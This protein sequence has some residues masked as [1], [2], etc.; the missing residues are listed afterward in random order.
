M[1]EVEKSNSNL[2]KE[3]E[4]LLL[5][6]SGITEDEKKEV[7]DQIDRVVEKNKISVTDELFVT[8]PVKKGALFPIL[9][10]VFALVL[11]AGGVFYAYRVF[12]TRQANLSTETQ[13]YLS[14]EGKLIEEIKKESEAQL[15]RKEE[16][17]SQIQTELME[18]DRQSKELKEN[19]EAEIAAREEQLKKE[20]ETALEA[21]R[22]KLEEEGISEKEINQRLSAIESEKR[23]QYENQ[24][25]SFRQ[26]TEAA[27]QE[28]ENELQQA[29]EL[30]EEVLERANRERLQLE[31]ETDRKISEL[32]EDFE[33]QR[34]ALQSEKSEAQER[35]RELS[36]LREQEQLVSDQIVGAYETIIEKIENSQYD[37]AEVNIEQLKTLLADSSLSSLP[38]IA[39]RREIDQYLLS[40]LKEHLETK[41]TETP[42]ETTSIV[43]AAN[44]L[45]GARELVERGNEALSEG[46]Q[47]MAKRL[48][49]TALTEVPALYKAY[50]ELQIIERNEYTELVDEKIA[51]G[52][53]L[54]EEGNIDAAISQ[55]REGITAAT[56]AEANVTTRAAGNI[57]QVLT[58]RE[59]RSVEEKEREIAR[60][61][62]RIERLVVSVEELET[63]VAA[64]NE[65]IASLQEQ[66]DSR[67]KRITSL[68]GIIE[69]RNSDMKRLSTSIDERNSSIEQLRSEITRQKNEIE[70]LTDRLSD[71]TL[72][73]ERL[74]RSLTGRE[75]EAGELSKS[76]QEKD[77]R[78]SELSEE[79]LRLK[80]EIDR[81]ETAA[82]DAEMDYRSE[83]AEKIRTIDTLEADLESETA[84]A[85]ALKAE[86]EE[87]QSTTERLRE[88]ITENE[89]TIEE[90]EE[91]L[92]ALREELDRPREVLA[93][94]ELEQAEQTGRI[95]AFNDVIDYLVY[96]SAGTTTNTNLT[97]HVE[98]LAA[99]DFHYRNTIEEI[100]E[101]IGKTSAASPTSVGRVETKLLGTISSVA[102][103]TVVIE[104]LVSMPV[105]E[106]TTVVVK[107]KITANREQ[108]IARGSVFNVTAGRIAARVQHFTS[109]TRRPRVMDLVYLEIPR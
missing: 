44:L 88:E 102:T 103:N 30:T 32:E 98:R 8:T 68:S 15:L 25:E 90:L 45:I 42:V 4:V 39:K 64:R 81:L 107:R 62:N 20:L 48:Y 11:V 86:V 37:A 97:R 40:T 84:A 47:K 106:G 58:G 16:E 91:Q 100:Q 9:I 66:I 76:I 2:P 71:K 52:N 54:L 26:E 72:E 29:R 79:V 94:E 28:K 35:L 17:I 69:E 101:V 105:Q 27:L 13:A 85:V 24:L 82:V 70:S 36:T 10:N 95:E 5:D 56:G 67:D 92:A 63:A 74:S 34:R 93:E 3:E 65:N 50:T 77:T 53:R 7:L 109:E 1:S 12:G 55:Y 19:M 87:E 73:A 104:P 33:E 22:R 21:E 41:T 96:I 51:K 43:E 18:L 78:L 89:S 75:G 83:I 46:Q 80:D 38:A 14:T 49:T 59:R 23:E 99:N 6:E 57:V 61:N 108:T 31:E 60:L